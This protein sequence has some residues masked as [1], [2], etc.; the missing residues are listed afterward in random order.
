MDFIVDLP[1]SRGHTVILMVV[2]RFSK[3]CHCVP[4]KKLPT[5]QELATVF[6][7]EVFRLQGLPKEIVSDRGSQFVSRFW[8]AFCSQLGIRLSF[9]SA[10]H[11]QS[12]GA[13]ERSNQ[14]LEQFLRCHVSDH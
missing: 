7:R 14:A 3:M 5:A 4:F 6:A 13:A 9:S 12:N 8:R 1:V 10:Y 11:P 2:D